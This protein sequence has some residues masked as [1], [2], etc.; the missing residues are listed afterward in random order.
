[1]RCR[2]PIFLLLILFS[3]ICYAQDSTSLWTWVKG[4]VTIPEY[5]IYGQRGVASKSNTPGPRIESCK[6]TD[7]A[8]KLWVL[9]GQSMDAL[10]NRLVLNDL[11]QY[12]PSADK[13]TWISGDS[14][15]FSLPVYGVKGVPDD[16]N[17][18]GFVIGAA[19][20]TDSI[21][22]FWLYNNTLWK[23][24]PVTYQ[25]T[26]INGD[27]TIVDLAPVYGVKGV[28][29]INNTPGSS[30]NSTTWVDK[31]G[32]FWMFGS[33]SVYSNN[34]WK[35]DPSVNMWAWMK[36]DSI[37]SRPAVY[38]SKGVASL[39]NT[40]NARLNCSSFTDNNGDLWLFGG[41]ADEGRRWPSGFYNDLWKYSIQLNQ[42][43]WVNGDS[44]VD[45]IDEF[46][47]KGIFSVLNKPGG[48]MAGNAWVDPSGNFWLQG[49]S[50]Y[51]NAPL[52]A[53]WKYNPSTN[54]WAWIASAPSIYGDQGIADKKNYPG[55]RY[56]GLTW[57]DVSGNFWLFAGSRNTSYT[58]VGGFSVGDLFNDLWKYDPSTNL[59]SWM[60][61]GN[62][63]NY[64]TVHGVKGVADKGNNP[65]PRRDANNWIDATDNLWLFGGQNAMSNDLWKYSPVSNTWMWIMGDSIPNVNITGVFGIRGVTA[66]G[67]IPPMRVSG[68]SWKDNNGNFWLFGGIANQPFYNS[69]NDLWKY[70]P[71][72]GMW[73]WMHGEKITDAI[74]VFGTKGIAAPQNTPGAL[75]SS[76]TWVDKTGNL[77]LYG[78]SSSQASLNVRSGFSNDL[79]KYSVNTNQW[80]WVQGDDT[81]F[82]TGH[83]GVKGIAS[84]ANRP[85][86]RYRSIYWTDP[87]GNFWLYGGQAAV[88]Q[89]SGL[90]TAADLNDL[91]KYTPTTNQ[92]TWMHGDTTIFVNGIYQS[93]PIVFG[94]KGKEAASN[95]PGPIESSSSWTDKNGDLWLMG[96]FSL[97]T[98]WRY[99][100]KTNRWAWMDGD[101]TFTSICTY[102]PQGLPS[103][104]S[105]PGPR[106][107]SVAWTDSKGR[108][109]LYSGAAI[110]KSML[111]DFEDLWRFSPSLSKPDSTTGDTTAVIVDSTVLAGPLKI[112]PN[113]FRNIISVIT[114]STEPL[115]FIKA[116]SLTGVLL[117]D[118]NTSSPRTDIDMSRYPA[119]AYMILAEDKNH[120]KLGKKLVIKQ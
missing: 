120:K 12:D 109:W 62:S 59:W 53:L 103:P 25:W 29:G 47:P 50:G 3:T 33:S 118:K 106:F 23:Y 92:W 86:A 91:W 119:G 105:N 61:G 72:T 52:P 30:Y 79:W 87:D 63:G 95:T 58:G 78:G 48:N 107:N 112:F 97:N 2:Q 24:N 113:P 67:N 40:P 31:K 41:Y 82:A 7:K 84:A 85:G 14:T 26:W 38:G 15:T 115:A 108:F 99:N 10:Q 74:P 90:W 21:G 101:T 100:R 37:L 111:L 43:T 69:L 68:V 93:I 64:A 60:K 66:V 81:V 18:P 17:H 89:P 46:G 9:G 42:W 102:G 117:I 49:G 54:L 88:R 34:L 44:V 116:Y 16:K 8:G 4:D 55:A 36:G 22:N 80:T 39:L 77:W 51:F 28:A 35:Y 45:V 114:G 56:L 104:E 11:W 65:G 110:E 1:M 19:Y 57:T 73:A 70:D 75:H 27:S 5:A 76:A 96:G 13:W 20:W 83:Y 32:K 94:N 6:W 71:L 98:L